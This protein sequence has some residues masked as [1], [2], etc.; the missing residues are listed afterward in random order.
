MDAKRLRVSLE[1][2]AKPVVRF[3]SDSGEE[4]FEKELSPTEK[5]FQ[6]VEAMRLE[7]FGRLNNRSTPAQAEN[8]E[9]QSAAEGELRSRAAALEKLALA[10]REI[11]KLTTLFKIVQARKDAKLIAFVPDTDETA[12][13]SQMAVC[14]QDKKA[15]L[16][17][18][19]ERVGKEYENSLELAKHRHAGYAGLMTLSKSFVVV[20]DRGFF[21]VELYPLQRMH[22]QHADVI[23]IPVVFSKSDVQ[24]KMPPLRASRIQIESAALP[25]F[26]TLRTPDTS[27]H[28]AA[29][30]TAALIDAQ[31]SRFAVELFRLLVSGFDSFSRSA[32]VP[33]QL[34][35]ER[36]GVETQAASFSIN[37]NSSA[38]PQS[39]SK[40]DT[41]DNRMDVDSGGTHEHENNVLRGALLSLGL[42]A[43]GERKQED[44]EEMNAAQT[45]QR[46]TET[47]QHRSARRKLNGTLEKTFAA[48]RT[49]CRLAM[50]WTSYG[51][52][53]STLCVMLNKR[54]LTTIELGANEYSFNCAP[55][56]IALH[57]ERSVALHLLS[58]IERHYKEFTGRPLGAL[59]DAIEL[60]RLKLQ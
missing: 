29:N 48:L 2:Y 15:A 47:F 37:L 27:P 45:A 59:A 19:A 58:V 13:L 38:L 12:P 6:Q 9:A 51:A 32:S 56:L 46:I 7:Q 4:T 54:R 43:L 50:H 40:D 30:C 42:K 11:D 34:T 53:T 36:I 20:C 49:H 16:K 8:S 35:V 5:F 17:A 52:T 25:R 44:A 26:N 18:L 39:E 21:F 23:R 55:L 24:L 22:S 33:V 1:A 28:G 3:I 10:R 60:E 14:F 57:G 31:H 41:D